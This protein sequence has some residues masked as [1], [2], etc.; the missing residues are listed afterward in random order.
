MCLSRL[1]RSIAGS[2]IPTDLN[3]DADLWVMYGWANKQEVGGALAGHA[4]IPTI[5][6]SRINVVTQGSVAIAATPL[7]LALLVA[8]AV[9]ENKA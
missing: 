3:L 8:A 5:T 2:N 7:V 9:F 6:S 1:T 4:E